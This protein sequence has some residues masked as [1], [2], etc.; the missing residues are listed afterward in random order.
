MLH[1]KGSEIGAKPVNKI[2]VI[3]DPTL[4]KWQILNV[5]SFLISGIT[6][7]NPSLIGDNYEDGQGNIYLPL[8]G[9]PVMVYSADR[10]K[11]IEILEKCH[12]REIHPAIF[13]R[14]MF[15]TSNDLDN[16]NIV[17]NVDAKDL[18]LV[19]LAL[20]SNRNKVDKIVKGCALFK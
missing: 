9:Q 10:D 18:D 3:L 20:C 14:G 17:K 11:F 13:A 7:Q 2:A 4:E 19:G 15:S 12:A 5:T 8:L 1:K 6:H 16:R